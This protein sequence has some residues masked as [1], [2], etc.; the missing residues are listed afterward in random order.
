M[1][2]NKHLF[3]LA[4]FCHYLLTSGTNS[5]CIPLTATACHDELIYATIRKRLQIQLD[6][7]S[8]KLTSATA[9]LLAI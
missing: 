9:T 8:G 4:N 5:S 1:L 3:L 7:S 2:A 6:V